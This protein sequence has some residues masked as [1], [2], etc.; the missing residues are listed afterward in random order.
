MV[1]KATLFDLDGTLTSTRKEYWMPLVDGVASRHGKINLTE[2]QIARFWFGHNRDETI[3][4]WGLSPDVFWKTFRELDSLEA[5]ERSVFLFE[6]V[7]ILN[8]LKGNGIKLGLVTQ[9]PPWIASM[10]LKKIPVEFDSVVFMYENPPESR[11]KPHPGG[12]AKCL[13]EL[14]VSPGEAVYI[15]NSEEDFLTARNAGMRFLLL[16]RG[17]HETEGISAERIKSLHEL[18]PL[19]GLNK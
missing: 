18:V 11:T 10:Q 9:A 6:D 7:K 4:S 16:D 2:N 5:R 19:L 13:N 8:E 3:S 1:L 17:E 14:G 12:I 15:G